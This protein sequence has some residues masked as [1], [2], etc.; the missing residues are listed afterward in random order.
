MLSRTLFATNMVSKGKSL[1][2]TLV[3]PLS[4]FSYFPFPPACFPLV[5]FETVLEPDKVRRM[6]NELN[7]VTSGSF[8]RET[9]YVV[10]PY[11]I[12]TFFESLQ[13]F[14]EES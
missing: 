13:L 10:F 1:G 7:G 4:I 3:S 14:V 2:H 8:N 6:N 5:T 11:S 9:N 12:T